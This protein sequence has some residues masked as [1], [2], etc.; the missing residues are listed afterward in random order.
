M[1]RRSANDTLAKSRINSRLSDRNFSQHFRTSVTHKST[2]RPSSCRVTTFP[3]G[4]TV[5]IFTIAQ[6]QSVWASPIEQ[7]LCQTWA[8]EDPGT[9]TRYFV[10]VKDRMEDTGD[11]NAPWSFRGSLRYLVARPSNPKLL[12]LATESTRIKIQGFC[13]AVW[14]LDNPS[15]FFE[16]SVNMVSFDFL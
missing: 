9:K 4:F 14:S 5:E 16:D 11:W 1:P 2:T 8:A 10:E 15:E 12:H 6:F 3:V 13:R 7:R